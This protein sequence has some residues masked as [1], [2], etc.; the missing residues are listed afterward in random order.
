MDAFRAAF[1]DIRPLRS[2]VPPAKMLAL[3]APLTKHFRKVVR[4]SP[5]REDVYLEVKERPPR[6]DY[7]ESDDDSYIYVLE[8]IFKDLKDENLPKIVV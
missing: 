5:V 4:A 1:K 3:T 2:I 8:P 6:D 7:D